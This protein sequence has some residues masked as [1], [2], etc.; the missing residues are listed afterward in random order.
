MHALNTEFPLPFVLSLPHCSGR[1]PD[2]LR[3]SISLSDS[4]IID[5]VDLGTKEIFGEFPAAIIVSAQWSRLVVDLNRARDER[6]PKGVIPHLDYHSREVYAPGARPN[7]AQIQ[8]IVKAYYRPYHRLLSKAVQ[9][10]EIRGLFD[11]HSL[12]GVGPPEAPDAGRKRPDIVLSNNGDGLG[13]HIP[14]RGEATCSPDKLAKMKRAFQ[15][16]GFSVALNQP[17]MGGFITAHYGPPLMR[18]GKFAVQIEINQALFLLTGTRP[19]SDEEMM[20]VRK[21]IEKSFLE[22]AV[23]V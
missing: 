8:R 23:S 10:H 4:E 9:R 5:S 7:E 21:R 11:C 13:Q 6:G 3:S 19:W 18:K 22:I 2:D 17:Y 12:S 14:D 16:N 1:I 20:K 15:N